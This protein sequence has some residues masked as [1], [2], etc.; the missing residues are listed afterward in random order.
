MSPPGRPVMPTSPAAAAASPAATTRPARSSTAA[1]TAAAGNRDR[2]RDLPD[3]Q[4]AGRRAIHVHAGHAI[5][6]CGHRGCPPSGCRWTSG[7]LRARDGGERL[8]E[9]REAKGWS[10]RQLGRVANVSGHIVARLEGIAGTSTT[11]DKAARIA[12]ELGLTLFDLFTSEEPVA[13][14]T[15]GE[16]TRPPAKAGELA[17][18][19]AD[20]L[21]RYC[22]KHGYWTGT[23]AA[24]F[25]GARRQ[26]GYAQPQAK[27]VY[28]A[29]PFIA[30]LYRRSEVKEVARRRRE[31]KTTDPQ[32]TVQSLPMGEEEGQVSRG[33]RSPHGALQ[34]AKQTPRQDPLRYRTQRR[35]SQPMAQ[36]LERTP[37]RGA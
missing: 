3:T 24:D 22:E 13:H 2:R 33:R 28:V 26:D 25:L 19:E 4:P 21:K 35:T 23:E 37:S 29:A 31:A 9:A 27:D 6:A 18:A 32:R 5:A 7:Y 16:R 10:R 36:Q 20:R 14:P 17:K 8:R 11:R 30:N 15:E 1:A 12:G 34:R